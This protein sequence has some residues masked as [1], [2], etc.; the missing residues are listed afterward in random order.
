M[1]KRQIPQKNL[2]ILHKKSVLGCVGAEVVLDEAAA[3]RIKKES[4]P[5]AAFTAAPNPP[6]LDSGTGGEAVALSPQQVRAV[7]AS[8]LLSLVQGHSKVRCGLFSLS[9]SFQTRFCTAVCPPVRVRGHVGPLGFA[10]AVLAVW[11]AGLRG[12]ASFLQTCS[13]RKSDAT[14]CKASGTCYGLWF[15]R[16]TPTAFAE[17]HGFWVFLGLSSRE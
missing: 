2:R 12:H 17:G 8:K 3:E 14:S 5:P 1:C 11:R 15:R 4:P 9:I 16:G 6:V 13:V 7:L 10:H